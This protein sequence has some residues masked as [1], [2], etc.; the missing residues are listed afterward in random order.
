MSLYEYIAPSFLPIDVL[1][2]VIGCYKHKGK[3]SFDVALKTCDDTGG[4]II[5]MDS[6][7]ENTAVAGE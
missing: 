4:Y 5:G 1:S 7:M 2:D 6:E 3:G